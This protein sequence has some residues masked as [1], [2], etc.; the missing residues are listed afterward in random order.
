MSTMV[1][2]PSPEQ[3]MWRSATGRSAP[4]VGVGDAGGAAVGSAGSDPSPEHPARNDADSSA[5]TSRPAIGRMPQ[6]RPPGESAV[7]RPRRDPTVTPTWL[8]A[9]GAEH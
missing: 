9:A 3:T 8:R 2:E 5:G 4:S 1:G 6:T 7:R